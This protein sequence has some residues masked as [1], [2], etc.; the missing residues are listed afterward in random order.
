MPSALANVGCLGFY[1]NS[2]LVFETLVVEGADPDLT[3]T[4]VV[5]RRDFEFHDRIEC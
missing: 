2:L 4:R 3:T 1:P 5:L